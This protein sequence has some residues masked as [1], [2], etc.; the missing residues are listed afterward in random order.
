[1][2]YIARADVETFLNLTL[3]T[4]GQNLVDAI[5]PAVEAYAENYCNRRW[6]VNTPQTEVFDGD[7][8]ILTVACPPIASV[9]SIVIDGTILTTSDYKV[10]GSYIR[11]LNAPYT[12]WYG[13]DFAYGGSHG[14]RNIVVTYVSNAPL[15]A[16][17]K[18]ALIRWTA[19][20]FKSSEDAGKTVKSTTVGSVSVDFLAQDGIP[21]YVQMVLDRY[22]LLPV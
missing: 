8:A 10:Y 4:S 16:D 2:S 14:Y 13:S 5:I 1:M 21:K 17:L 9:T 11:L 18:H 6:N 22:R 3:T 15:P 19:D 20:I 12:S 7:A